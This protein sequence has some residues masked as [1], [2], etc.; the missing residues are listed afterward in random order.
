MVRNYKNIMVPV[1][2]SEPSIQAFKKAVHIA[3]RNGANLYLVTVV[4]KVDNP[5]E[6]EQIERDREGFFAAL[7]AYAKHENQHVERKVK[8]GNAKKLIAEELVKDWNIDLIIMGA[9]GKGNIAK[10]VLGSI[11]KHVTKHAR[12]DVLIAR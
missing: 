10:M 12:C 2:G 11:T 1:D 6:A 3:K 8:F 9:T 5:E 7:E 4:D